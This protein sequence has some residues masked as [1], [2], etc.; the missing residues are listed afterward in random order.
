MMKEFLDKLN[1]RSIIA[2][3]LVL[4]GFGIA[5][6]DPNLRNSF[7]DLAKV[8]IGGYLGQMVPEK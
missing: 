5:I 2:L 7:A 4:G 6:A 1:V 8:G 3:L